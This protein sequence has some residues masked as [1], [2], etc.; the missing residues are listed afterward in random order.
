MLLKEINVSPKANLSQQKKSNN[1]N[2][3][4]GAS[5]AAII[6]PPP[7][8]ITN[9][10]ARLKQGTKALPQKFINLN[11]RLNNMFRWVNFTEQ[12]DGKL[13]SQEFLLGNDAIIDRYNTAFNIAYLK[14]VQKAT[15]DAIGV[16]QMLEEALT[17]RT[18]DFPYEIDS[19]GNRI[20]LSE[21]DRE[22]HFFPY[23]EGQE[24]TLDKLNPELHEHLTTNGLS[25]LNVVKLADGS[26]YKVRTIEREVEIEAGEDIPN[27]FA[28]KMTAKFFNGIHYKKMD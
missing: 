16:K 1:V 19:E 4:G 6:T 8:S 21:I 14:S 2:F 15:P 9:S 18:I 3:A 7:V 26:K 5:A 24:V 20:I 25:G 23:I 11:K 10:L 17:T 27:P 28:K 13:V 22:G 12:A